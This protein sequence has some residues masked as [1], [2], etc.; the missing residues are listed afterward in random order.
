MSEWRTTVWTPG[1]YPGGEKEKQINP[2]G[3]GNQ[4]ANRIISL[5]SSPLGE[6]F[7]GGSSKGLGFG[8]G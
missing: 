5:F 7:G 4:S 3:E 1:N 2:E 6:G 8:I